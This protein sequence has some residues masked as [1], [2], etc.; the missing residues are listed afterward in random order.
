VN[1]TVGSTPRALSSARFG[2]ALFGHADIPPAGETVFKVPLRLAV[3]D[4]DQAGHGVSRVEG[5]RR[6]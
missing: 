2:S 6:P 3:A 1:A 5:K 4:Q